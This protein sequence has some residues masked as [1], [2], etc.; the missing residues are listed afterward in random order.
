[1]FG[2]VH[3]QPAAQASDTTPDLLWQAAIRMEDGN[4]TAAELRMRAAQRA[5]KEAIEKGMSPEEVQRKIAD[6][7]AVHRLAESAR[8][9]REDVGQWARRA[10]SGRARALAV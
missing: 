3:D 9:L 1:M 10:E 6:L 5:L 4:L 8:D 7:Q 2:I